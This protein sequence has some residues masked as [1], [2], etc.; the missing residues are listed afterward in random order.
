[1]KNAMLQWEL[2]LGEAVATTALNVIKALGNPPFPGVNIAAATLAGT[3]GGIQVATLMA[4]QPKMSDFQQF[5]TGGMVIGPGTST[6]DS[7]PAMLSNGEAVINAK[8]TK[9]F[10]PQLDM[11]NKMGGGAP[12]IP[13]YNQGGIIQGGTTNIDTSGMEEIMMMMN[14]RPIKTYVVSQ[15]I[16]NAQHND[17]VLK[18]RTT[19]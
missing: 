19:F 18:N 10:L 12:L 13:S 16:T 7:I 14:N 5:S 15:D 17:S 6:S 8:S 4:Q 2:R 1:M 3:L 9:M 11:I